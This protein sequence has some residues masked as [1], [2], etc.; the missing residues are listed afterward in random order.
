MALFCALCEKPIKG[1]EISVLDHEQCSVA[2]KVAVR[3]ILRGFEEGVFVRNVDA[4][5]QPSWAIKALPF[6][7]A[8]G[9]AQKLTSEDR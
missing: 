5:S 7:A 1:A 9:Q 2:L 3:T 8:L 6:L 4:D